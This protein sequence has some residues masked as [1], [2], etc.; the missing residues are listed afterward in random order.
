[1]YDLAQHK[2]CNDH[3]P[4]ELHHI[5]DSRHQGYMSYQHLC[6]AMSAILIQGDDVLRVL[7][8]ALWSFN[9]KKV[10]SVLH[11]KSVQRESQNTMVGKCD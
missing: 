3:K 1:M 6:N 5:A 4:I 7:L 9:N 8:T 11:V 2:G 10:P